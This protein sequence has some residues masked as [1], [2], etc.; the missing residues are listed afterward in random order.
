MKSLKVFL[1]ILASIAAGALVGVLFAPEKGSRTRK[2]IL[3]K[4]E[5]YADVLKDKLDDFLDTVSEKYD[6][7]KKKAEGLVTNGKAKYDEAKKEVKN[8]TV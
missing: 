8:A 2:S 5:D 6:N 3:N 4:S 7:T 1:S